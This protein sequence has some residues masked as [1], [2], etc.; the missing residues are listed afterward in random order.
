LIALYLIAVSLLLLMGVLQLWE[1][2]TRVEQDTGPTMVSVQFLGWSLKIADEVRLL[3]IV[4]L[5]GALGSMVHA[6][7]SLYDYVGH[8]ELVRSWLLKYIL[9]PFSGATLGLIFYAVIRSGFLSPQATVDQTNPFGF[10]ALSGLV[11]MFSEQAVLK[12]KEVAET[13]LFRPKPGADALSTEEE[14]AGA[15][16]PGG[17]NANPESPEEQESEEI[18]LPAEETTGEGESPADETGA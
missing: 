3:L 9:L 11:G 10:V 5:A 6:L 18:Q 17:G 1:P 16:S 4:V 7:R 14:E 8:R 13:L 2:S 12:L 15:E